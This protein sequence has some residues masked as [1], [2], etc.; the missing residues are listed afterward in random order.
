ME[1]GAL[2]CTPT[3]P[4]CDRCPLKSVCISRIEDKVGRVPV[5]KS[6][7]KYED[8]SESV[9]LLETNNRFLVRR[10]A[11]G[12]RWAGLFDFPRFDI[13]HTEDDPREFLEQAMLSQ[14][15]IE[16]QLKSTKIEF[17]HAV[18]RF[19]IRL[20]CYRNVSKIGEQKRN[21]PT[22]SKWV[23]RN[24]LRELAFNVTARK[25]ADQLDDLN[26]D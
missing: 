13:T 20:S 22:D 23:H 24:R 12:E 18:T 5:K 2:V 8:L 3:R 11:E 15:G 1:L 10:C 17:K 26:L 9:V 16:L 19:R 14:Y 4:K 7:T 21:L 25:I 6:K